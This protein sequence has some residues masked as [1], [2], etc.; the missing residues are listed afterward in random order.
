M[1]YYMEQVAADFFIAEEDKK[2]ALMAIKGMELPRYIR[3]GKIK[4]E[5]CLEG[6]LDEWD[7]GT[8]HDEEENI[9]GIL[10]QGEK[11]GDDLK[12]FEAIAP[13]V[14]SGSFIEMRGEDGSMWRWKF[15]DGEVKEVY[16]RV[17]WG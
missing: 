10:F 15:K 16:P 9:I 1:G 8:S 13:F 7:W 5:R 14:R 12:L 11:L 17:E 6:A 3:E 2:E 4:K